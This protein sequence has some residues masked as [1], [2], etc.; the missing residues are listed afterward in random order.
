[1]KFNLRNFVMRTLETMKNKLDEYQVRSYA[2]SWYS[3]G[4]LTD[5][6]MTTI[7][8]WYAVEETT[9]QVEDV[10]VPNE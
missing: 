4:V 6:D 3:K 1:M 9:E 7:D 5:E 10:E 2:L 8:G